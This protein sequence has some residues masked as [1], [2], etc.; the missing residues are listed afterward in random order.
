MRIRILALSAVLISLV[1]C[2]VA[3]PTSALAAETGCARW[4]LEASCSTAPDR[5]IVGDP[6]TATVTVRNT[7]DQALLKV[8]IQLRGSLGRFAWSSTTIFAT[9]SPMRML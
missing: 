4:A 7:G 8:T 9:S 6:F 5:I 3:A 2:S 1:L